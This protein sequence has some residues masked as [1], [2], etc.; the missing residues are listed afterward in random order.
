MS[1][2][3]EHIGLAA[4]YVLGTLDTLERVQVETM[5]TV[6]AGFRDLVLGWEGKLGELHGMVG[7]IE[8]PTHVWNHIHAVINGHAPPQR[9][10]IAVMAAVEAAMAGSADP[11]G[12]DASAPAAEE[13]PATPDAMEEP[14]PAT[15]AAE[16]AP[17]T[18]APSKPAMAIV[19]PSPVNDRTPV[20]SSREVVLLGRSARRWR[21]IAGL[22][23]TM[24]ACIG[25]FLFVERYRPELL[26]PPLRVP[27]K[28]EVVK[29]ETPA[30]P[31][32]VAPP[33]QAGQLVALLQKDTAYPGFI[34]TF[35]MAA[36][37]LTVR[38]LMVQAEEGKSYE[39]WLIS[40]KIA[41]PKSLGLV[42][43][44]D[45]TVQP[46]IAD[47]DSETIQSAVYAVTME[48]AGGSPTGVP[49]SPPIF[50]GRLIEVIPAAAR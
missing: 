29:V 16:S 8:P 25:G 2:S 9:P 31:A 47:F 13:S 28:I 37:T 50:A 44:T 46:A 7:P 5:M 12:A 35:D 40:N 33:A 17:D 42:G 1:Y 26:P 18:A 30:P 45:F 20:R 24:A 21:S 15:T 11:G 43:M 36:R 41:A 4:E 34:L 3:E 6:D 32:P 49:T 22:T 27:P 38:R 23:T 48:P 14:A 10:D 39:L 19:P